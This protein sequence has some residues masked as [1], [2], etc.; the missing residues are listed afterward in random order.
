MLAMAPFVTGNQP[1][2]T[3]KTL[4]H[5]RDHATLLPPT[6]RV[7]RESVWENGRTRLAAGDGWTMRVVHQRNSKTATVEVTAVNVELCD[8]IAA[9]ATEGMTEPPPPD[10]AVFMGFWYA[11]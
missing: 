6:S 4:D 3:T 8:R 11:S 7:L 2:A 9:V 10:E 1:Y 5:V